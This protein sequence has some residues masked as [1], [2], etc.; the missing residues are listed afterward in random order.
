[1]AGESL[2]LR[3]K[4]RKFALTTM[5]G[6][7]V[8]YLLFILLA[9]S[10][11]RKLPDSNA[12]LMPQIRSL[13]VTDITD[14][15]ATLIAS[16]T[17]EELLVGYGFTFGPKDSGASTNLPAVLD[18]NLFT[19][20]LNG[21]EGATEYA[22]KAYIDNGKELRLF[23][24]TRTF[25]T[26]DPP[27]VIEDPDTPDEPAGPD[28]PGTDSPAD[29]QEPAQVSYIDI[30]DESFR[31]WILARFDA[32]QD[33]KLS[34]TEAGAISEIELNTD[35]I[36]SLSGIE[37]FPNLRRLHA[38][39]TRTGDTGLGVLETVDLSGNP[40]LQQLYIPHNRVRAVDLS[41]T[42]NLDHVELYMNDIEALDVSMLKKVT[43]MNVGRNPIKRLDVRG[44]D[45]LDEL[46]CDGA[47][48]AELMLD[49][50]VLRYIDCSGT[51]ITEL[52]LSRCP[53]INTVD[54][55]DCKKLTT[56]WL[57]KGQVPGLLRKDDSAKIQ[58]YD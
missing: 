22:F 7:R 26:L 58:Y 34:S 16:V 30:A 50:K 13:T 36:R 5:T 42:P 17:Q 43:L 35:A 44:L 9:A 31:K 48:I 54:C 47:P 12:V 19:I 41:H 14:C 4:K 29:P 18:G 39:G 8:T 2:D 37:Q 11:G 1:M 46:H 55:T 38:E 3:P 6:K 20:T 24:D 40:Q 45:T 32:N 10:C 15:S 28:N 23:S 53:K 52:D 56:I 33:G 21:L 57:A 27:P 25:T 51:D 49:N